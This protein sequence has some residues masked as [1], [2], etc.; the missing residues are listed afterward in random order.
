MADTT[1]RVNH[2]TLTWAGG[3]HRFRVVYAE[4]SRFATDPGGLGG[5]E[6]AIL[7]RLLNDTWSAAD[8][9]TPILVGLRGGRITGNSSGHLPALPSA[10]DIALVR[11]YVQARPLAESVF[12]AQAVLFATIFGVP[13][14]LANRPV[15]VADFIAA[16][17]AAMREG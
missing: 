8:V 4:P 1:D 9:S 5:A 14:A 7:D 6:R 13:T 15:A 11:D 17:N 3:T 12:L 2:A 16:A 10:E